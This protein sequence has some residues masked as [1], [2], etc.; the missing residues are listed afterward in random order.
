MKIR[1]SSEKNDGLSNL[2]NNSGIK[3]ISFSD[4]YQSNEDSE[5]TE[6]DVD[7][8]C[9]N[10]YRDADGQDL[11]LVDG[12]SYGQALTGSLKVAVASV[13]RDHHAL[14]TIKNDGFQIVLPRQ[15]PQILHEVARAIFEDVDICECDNEVSDGAWLEER[16]LRDYLSFKIPYVSRIFIRWMRAAQ[17][18]IFPSTRKPN[19]L[20]FGDWTNLGIE[21]EN[22]PT[23]WT[24]YYRNIR[25]CAFVCQ[26]SRREIERFSTSPRYS[27]VFEDVNFE[28]VLYRHPKATSA[29][30]RFALTT[31]VRRVLKVNTPWIAYY[32]SQ[33]NGL[34]NSYQPA[35]IELPAELFEPYSVA[36]MVANQRLVPATLMLDGHDS[37]GANVPVLRNQT[38]SVLRFSKFV[39]FSQ[40]QI[41]TAQNLRI[42]DSMFVK[43]ESPFL[44]RYKKIENL[45]QEYGVIIMTWLPQQYN[46]VANIESPKE[47]LRAALEVAL[48]HTGK[49]IGIKVKDE[50]LEGSYVRKVISDLAAVDRVD[51]LVGAFAEHVQKTDFVI[52]GI[53]TAV[54]ESMMAGVPYLI[55]EPIDNGY[56]DEFLSTSQTLSLANIARDRASLVQMVSARTNSI[57]SPR[58]RFLGFSAQ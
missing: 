15:C 45:S 47:T 21:Y 49:R 3:T 53:S 48:Q 4:L 7:W 55:F 39:V 36:L 25:K 23:L 12:I 24:N 11:T 20:V 13:V 9:H 31:V 30:F 50:R 18:I 52:G 28:D 14:N 17:Q 2:D 16:I 10:W 38:N 8:F 56:S 57:N 1:I 51:I 27:Q 42:N 32:H 6:I 34:F 40:D 26:P 37:S 29:N 43:R 41:D 44:R 22:V 19:R 54:A 33:M 58:D 46:P 5:W 35:S